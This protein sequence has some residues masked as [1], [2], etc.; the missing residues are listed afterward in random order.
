MQSPPSNTHPSQSYATNS[1]LTLRNL[2]NCF[3]SKGSGLILTITYYRKNCK[4]KKNPQVFKRILWNIQSVVK[5][6]GFK[7]KLCGVPFV[8]QWLMSHNR[9]HEDAS[10]IPGLAQRV[11]DLALPW[12]VA[13]A[14]SCSST[15]TPGLGTSICCRYGPKKQNK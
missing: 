10:S 14:S 5:G 12:V 13:W 7:N 11:K 6:M 15:S 9:I 1:S 8:A 3:L 2:L 4:H